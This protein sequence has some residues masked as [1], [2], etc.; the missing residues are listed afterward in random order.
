MAHIRVEVDGTVQFDGEVSDWQAPP[1][2]PAVASPIRAA[3]MPPGIRTILA[4]ALCET[5]EKATGFKFRQ[6]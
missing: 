2:P 4:K 1:T 6:I 3:D 5:L